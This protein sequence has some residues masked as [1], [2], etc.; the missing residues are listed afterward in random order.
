MLDGLYIFFIFET[1]MDHPLEQS[2]QNEQSELYVFI[3]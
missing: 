1:V 3:F 2:K